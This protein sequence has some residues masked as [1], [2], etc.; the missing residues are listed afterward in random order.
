MR[1][2]RTIRGIGAVIAAGVLFL[3]AVPVMATPVT[4][5]G[6]TFPGGNA[7]FADSVV[8]YNPGSSVAPP[9][10]DPDNA[11]GAPDYS[12]NSGYVSLGIGGTLDLRFTDNSLTTSG[13]GA[14]DL[15]IFEIGGQVEPTYLYLS[16]DGMNWIS[17][18]QV[19]GATSGVD[20]DA[21][22]GSG[23]TAG[24]S[25]SYVRLVDTGIGLSG[26][27]FAGADIDAVGAIASA[28]PVISAPEPGA[29]ALFGLGLV[30]IGGVSLRNR[31]SRR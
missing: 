30:L 19:G 8:N 11:L 24:M 29:L 16:Q 3:A 18:G 7:S 28:A 12:G 5:G 20:I 21:F 9:Y 6:V 1:H 10:D 22:I 31:Y 17:I 26:Y 27:P 25:Y 2:T 4:Y 14:M 13:D 23:I 15:W